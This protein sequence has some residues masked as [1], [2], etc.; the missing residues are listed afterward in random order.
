MN[1]R[2]LKC[3]SQKLSGCRC[4]ATGTKGKKWWSKVSQQAHVFHGWGTA[5]ETTV[6]W[7]DRGRSSLWYAWRLLR[8]DPLVET[9]MFLIC[10]KGLIK[11]AVCILN[12]SLC[13]LNTYNDCLWVCNLSEKLEKAPISLTDHFMNSLASM[14][15]VAGGRGLNCLSSFIAGGPHFW[16]SWEKA[17]GCGAE[18]QR[19][20]S[21]SCAPDTVTVAIM[22]MNGSAVEWHLAPTLVQRS[23]ACFIVWGGMGW[24]YMCAPAPHCAYR[25]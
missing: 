5:P 8:E 19:T 22:L 20:I 3:L 15:T 1:R 7:G 12:N 21:P 13:T 10:I 6:T 25:S 18:E 2:N 24:R 16:N 23:L 14:A 9:D 17:P 4:V 11:I